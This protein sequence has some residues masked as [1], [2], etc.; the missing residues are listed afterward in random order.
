MLLNWIELFA[1]FL[2]VIYV[3]KLILFQNRNDI[4]N[5]NKY[6]DNEYR[7]FKIR[8]FALGRFGLA[9]KR[10]PAPVVAAARKASIGA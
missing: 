6:S 8:E 9:K 5:F 1:A 7:S 10:E 4:S 2:T 3:A